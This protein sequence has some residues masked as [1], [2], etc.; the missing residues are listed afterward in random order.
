[1]AIRA[2]RNRC[3]SIGSGLSATWKPIGFELAEL[4]YQWERPIAQ[5]SLSDTI[6][7]WDVEG[8]GGESDLN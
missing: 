4:G 5:H 8:D 7:K 2:D 3:R 1:M 6:L